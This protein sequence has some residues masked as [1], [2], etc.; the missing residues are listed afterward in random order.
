MQIKITAFA[1]NRLDEID[2]YYRGEGYARLGRKLR[3]AIVVKTKLLAK[4]PEM[5]QTE[6]YLLNLHQGHRYIVVESKYKLIYLEKD[7]IIYITDIFDTR[8]NPNKIRG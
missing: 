8:Q 7:R 6:E 4:N 2:D 5:G 1:R 3:K